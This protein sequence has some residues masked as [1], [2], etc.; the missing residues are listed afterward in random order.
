MS[1]D[2]LTISIQNNKKEILNSWIE[3]ILRDPLHRGDL[4]N[5]EDFKNLASTFI[6]TFS[7]LLVSSEKSILKFEVENKELTFFRKMSEKYLNLGLTPAEMTAD[8]YGLKQVMIDFLSNKTSFTNKSFWLLLE[9]IDKLN[10]F[11]LEFYIE[12]KEN[13]IENQRTELTELASPVIEL[14]DKILVLPLI[15][16]LDSNRTQIIMEKVLNSIS[17]IGSEV[18]IIDITGITIVDTL[19][20]QHLIKTVE[21]ARLMGAKALISGISPDI[22]Q[23]IISLGININTINTKSTLKNAFKEAIYMLQELEEKSSKLEN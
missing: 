22:A 6:S 4:I 8:I 10:L 12:E 13:I 3:S 14:W 15:G 16:T 11:M 21:A 5:D 1:N 23:T 17:E 19:V 7:K 20:A 18:I 9:K 2:N